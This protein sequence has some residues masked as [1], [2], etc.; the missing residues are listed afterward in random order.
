MAAY[1]QRPGQVPQQYSRVVAGA[2]KRPHRRGEQTPH[3]GPTWKVEVHA[4]FPPV[5][6]VESAKILSERSQGRKLRVSSM[7][8][9]KNN[10]IRCE[11]C[12]KLLGKG[13]ALALEIKCP[14]CGTVNS[15]RGTIP[16]PEPRDGQDEVPIDHARSYTFAR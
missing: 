14:R 8:K 16:N 10:D 15:L 6:L 5:M 12:N 7:I 4:E 13:I 11:H 3:H 1:W 9:Q 2:Y